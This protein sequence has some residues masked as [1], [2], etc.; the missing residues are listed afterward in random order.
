MEAFLFLLGLLRSSLCPRLTTP[1][2][3]SIMRTSSAWL[4]ESIGATEMSRTARNLPQLFRCSFSSRKK[5]HTKRLKTSRGAK[6]VTMRSEWMTPSS[7][8]DTDKV[9]PK[10]RA[11]SVRMAK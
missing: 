3:S 2:G 7:V 8:R 1:L 10:R 6:M 5:F 4:P 11:R 9:Q